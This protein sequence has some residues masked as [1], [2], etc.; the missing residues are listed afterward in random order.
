MH[1]EQ[2]LQVASVVG[3]AEV[4]SCIFFLLS[5]ISYVRGVSRGRGCT[6]TPLA[7][8]DWRWVLTSLFLT[9]C[10]ML[11]KEQGIVA[12]GVSATFDV[13]LHWDVFWEGLFHF[14]K[15][16]P[17]S[18]KRKNSDE[19]HGDALSGDIIVNG[20]GI[21]GVVE[22]ES[23]LTDEGKSSQGNSKKDLSMEASLFSD[24]AKRLGKGAYKQNVQEIA[25]TSRNS[26]G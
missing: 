17:R 6:L 26:Q 14:L 7:R 11:S 24:L 1:G 16:T 9:L 25:Q 13:I 2:F 3:R 4:L 22:E 8:T 10:A 18:P 12:I 15:T 21:G 23:S 20:S 19:V 5:I